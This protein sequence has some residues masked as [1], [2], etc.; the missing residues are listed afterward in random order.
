MKIVIVGD[1][2]V[3]AALA[4]R[5]SCESHDIVVIDNNPRRLATLKTSLDVIT[6]LGNG[7]SAAV[8]KEADVPHCDLLIAVTSMDELNMICC[9]LAKKLGAGHTVARVRNPDY[10]SYLMLLKDEL[11][12]SMAVNPEFAAAKEI[13]RLLCY[14][15]ASHI[16]TFAGGRAELI[17]YRIPKESVLSGLSLQKMGETIKARA[18]ICAVHRGGDVIIPNGDFV[19]Q[20]GDNI[21]I[22]TPPSELGAFFRCLGLYSHRIRKLM[23]VGGGRIAYYLSVM[24]LE[25]GMQVSVIEKDAGRAEELSDLLPKALIIH[26]D[27][28][29]PELLSE[30]G[31]ENA[32][33]FV[34]L[35][36]MDEENII[37]SLYARARMGGK[38]VTKVD[39]LPFVGVLGDLGLESM[40]SPKA[41]TANSIVSFVRGMQNSLGSNVETMHALMGGRIEALE[42]RIRENA[43]H[44][45][46]PLKN[47][48]FKPDLLVGCIVRKGR[49]IIPAGNDV[50]EAGDSV[51]V[52]TAN[53]MFDDFN[54]IF[55]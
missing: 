6:V 15:S 52:I 45:G 2:K 34:T 44:L 40:I 9:L 37:L 39:R 51:V 31:L 35:T 10:A 8:Q 3:G 13:R 42:F 38:V 55:R 14:P 5:L 16:E 17:E 11:G 20:E 4:E 47:L 53:R 49:T 30:E 21:F 27:G 32:D 41:L 48:P 33:A 23:I 46:V 25:Y 19:L 1:G 50:I 24:M 7:A 18:L 26:G 12:L 36:G 22:T 54:D 29:D 43:G 28:A